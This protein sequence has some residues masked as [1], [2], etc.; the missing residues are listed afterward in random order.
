MYTF[1]EKDNTDVCNSELCDSQINYT[2]TSQQVEMLNYLPENQRDAALADWEALDV[3]QRIE[4]RENSDSD[5]EIKKIE[6]RKKHAG[7]TYVC[8]MLGCSNNIIKNSQLAQHV[9]RH[10]SDLLKKSEAV[11]GK[12][13]IALKNRIIEHTISKTNNRS[14][15]SH[16]LCNDC[17]KLIRSDYLT[18]HKRKV[19]MIFKNQSSALKLA[20][21]EKAIVEVR[22]T[23]SCAPL[24]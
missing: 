23:A 4:H 15:S 22:W 10:H 8:P 19:H 14:C 5:K 21:E 7:N 12:S 16:T 1:N 9:K 6:E 18:R 20:S 11:G 24:K 2:L 17:G 3:V 13:L